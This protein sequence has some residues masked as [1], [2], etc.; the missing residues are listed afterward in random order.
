M[1]LTR[2]QPPPSPD[3]AP[4]V[5]L[6]P[7]Q[8]DVLWAMSLGLT[9]REIGERLYITEDT[10]GVHV[11]AVLRRMDARNRTDAAVMARTG[12]VHVYV[13]EAAA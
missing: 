9:D 4:V 6:T 7:R 8:A 13:K 3:N 2:W 12:L 5:V 11:R 10:A 1:S